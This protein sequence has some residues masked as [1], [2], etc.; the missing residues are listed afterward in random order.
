MASRTAPV[1]SE[2][3][4]MKRTS[5]CPVIS[6]GKRI[7]GRTV[8][9]SPGK[10]TRSPWRRIAST[11]SASASHKSKSCP[12]RINRHPIITPTW[13]APTKII[14]MACFSAS[15]LSNV[16]S[17][18]EPEFPHLQRACQYLLLF[19][20]IQKLPVIWRKYLGPVANL[21]AAEVNTKVHREQL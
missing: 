1:L 3:T 4:A 18:R 10:S 11:C 9:E 8:N 21:A 12:A 20:Q 6:L 14:F 13:P 5:Y 19:G 17:R 7:L 16:G 2:R 15:L